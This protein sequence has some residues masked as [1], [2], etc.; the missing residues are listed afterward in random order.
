MIKTKGKRK[1]A[2]V[3]NHESVGGMAMFDQGE[4]LSKYKCPSACDIGRVRVAINFSV[5]LRPSFSFAADLVAGARVAA[6]RI[7]RQ[8][9][10][11]RSIRAVSGFSSRIGTTGVHDALIYPGMLIS[12][13]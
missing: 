9:G 12:S 2:R 8:E 1:T 6:T 3:G 7:L 13:G 4:G 10:W 5:L 11:S